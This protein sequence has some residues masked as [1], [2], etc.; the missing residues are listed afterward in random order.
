MPVLSGDIKFYLTGALSD[1]GAQAD[2]NASLGGYRSST[3]ITS[4][5]LNNLFD[6]VSSA[7]ASSG[8]T[9]YRCICVQNTSLETLYNVISWFSA[10][11][12]P[13]GS[14]TH[15]FAIE[16]PET[17]DLTDGDCQTVVN[18]STAPSVNTTNHNGTGS[19]ISNWSSAI[20]KATGLSPMYGAHDDDLDAGEIMFVWI[21]RVCISGA[22]ARTGLSVTFKVEG[23]T[24]G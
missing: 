20:S 11:I 4:A 16:V 24:N 8:D 23:D 13:D 2:P 1:G 15:S 7:E 6:N 3:E 14:F 18:E 9:E 17:A 5:M 19:G 10:E 12:D 21:R 22:P